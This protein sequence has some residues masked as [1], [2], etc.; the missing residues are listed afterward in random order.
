MD[1]HVEFLK[2]IL[3][4]EKEFI[5]KHKPKLAGLE[6]KYG[7]D[8]AKARILQ[9]VMGVSK[10]YLLNLA[11]TND[12]FFVDEWWVKSKM[13]KIPDEAKSKFKQEQIQHLKF[14]FFLKMVSSIESQ[15]RVILRG[16]FPGVCGPKDGFKKV[17]EDLLSRVGLMGKYQAAFNLARLVRN[18]IHNNGMHTDSTTT[19][20]F[21]GKSY[22]LREMDQIDFFTYEFNLELLG[23]LIDAMVEITETEGFK[24]W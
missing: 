20:N 5:I 16:M 24:E 4:M 22:T 9:N 3:A 8:S 12:T 2:F 10:D 14:F 19:V 17:Y 11:S 18:T 7:E 15:M 21:N 1:M 6:D 13:D 23:S